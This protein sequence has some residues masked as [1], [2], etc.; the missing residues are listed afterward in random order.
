MA[1]L[2]KYKRFSCNFNYQLKIKEKND[3]VPVN[4]TYISMQIHLV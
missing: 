2:F 4:I 1:Q 3:F